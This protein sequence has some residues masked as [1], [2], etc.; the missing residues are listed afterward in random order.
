MTQAANQAGRRPSTVVS[1][2]YLRAVAALLV[3]YLHVFSLKLLQ[4]R[5]YY[6]SIG[7]FGV[8]IFFVISGF[9]MWTST[10]GQRGGVRRF[11][12]RRIIRVFP[13]WW[14]ALTVW[15]ASRAL[16]SSHTAPSD[17]TAAPVIMSYLLV[18]H[19]YSSSGKHIWPILAPGWTLQIE[20]VFYQIFALALL[21]SSRLVRFGF[22]SIVV[23]VAAATGLMFR[24]NSPILSTYTHPL[25]LEFGFGVVIA[26]LPRTVARDRPRTGIALI[27]A[28]VILLALSYP[29]AQEGPWRWLWWGLPAALIVLGGLLLEARLSVRVSKA[30]LLVGDASYSLYL[31]HPI[32]IGALAIFWERTHFVTGLQP[33]ALLFI[34]VALIGS[35]LTAIATYRFIEQPLLKKLT[36]GRRMVPEATVVTSDNI[37][38]VQPL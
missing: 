18:P 26:T 3:V 11:L 31:T 37:V 35:T 21:A 17:M 28:A 13:M 33:H 25:L 30:V 29:V 24:F 15:I 19:Y 1:I 9:I 22:V 34:P 6:E 23:V 4:G 10:S 32:T 7:A 38:R 16:V 20:W 2:Q 27:A 5:D 14:I 36:P 8:D 12:T